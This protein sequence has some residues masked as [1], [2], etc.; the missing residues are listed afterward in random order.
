MRTCPSCG[1]AEVN[2]APYCR[3]CNAALAGVAVTA[4]PLPTQSRHTQAPG[5][6]DHGAQI[7]SEQEVSTVGGVFR[8]LALLGGGSWLVITF[9][10]VSGTQAQIIS[11]AIAINCILSG[12][13]VGGALQ[14]MAH[15]SASL[16]RL[17]ENTCG[18]GDDGHVTSAE[19][20]QFWQQCEAG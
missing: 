18:T 2:E 19:A 3:A 5:L 11:A 14:L 13:I 17:E 6:R 7:T 12:F 20:R 1:A 10:M 9:T 4:A 15:I 8:I 16:R